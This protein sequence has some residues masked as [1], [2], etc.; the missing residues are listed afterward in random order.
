MSDDG[1]VVSLERFREARAHEVPL[2]T[3]TIDAAADVRKWVG[4][5]DDARQVMVTADAGEA[6]DK[7]VIM[8]PDQ[9]RALG[10]ALIGAA[11]LADREFRSK[12]TSG[13]PFD[14]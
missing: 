2:E 8:T 7:G 5:S 4:W 14:E 9:A 3:W 13:S 11:A 1:K 12:V 6:A 10:L